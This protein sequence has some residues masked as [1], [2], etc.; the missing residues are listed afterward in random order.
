VARWSKPPAA[1]VR[2]DFSHADDTALVDALHA[3][4]EAAMAEIVHRH[5]APVVAFARR[6]T[7]DAPRAEE[8]A[9]EVFVRLWERAE[10]FDADRGTL[11]AFLLALTHGRALDVVRSD[12]ARRRRE[13]RDAARAETTARG[14]DTRV[15]A[16]SVAD[17]VRTALASLPEEE[18]R[19]VE[20]AYFGGHSY[21]T[22]AR[23]LDQPEGTVKTRI[24]NGL[25]RLR[26]VLDA[27]DRRG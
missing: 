26:T 5:R 16:S 2:T 23:L 17:A 18:R 4:D 8:V 25:A 3:R 12:T 10:R 21:R 27:Q 6:L 20:L 15:E 19:A 14:A 7:G 13:E 11:R 9:Q 22:V 1:Q 24:R